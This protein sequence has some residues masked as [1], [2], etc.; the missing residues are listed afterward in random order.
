MR[1][2]Y[3]RSRALAP[4]DSRDP[5]SFSPEQKLLILDVWKRSGLPSAEFGELLGVSHKTLYSWR[6][7]LEKEGPEG[8][9]GKP[10]GPIPGSRIDP[11]TRRAILLIKEDN[12]EYGCDRISQLLY[13]GPG[14]GVSPGG[15]ARVLKE[16]GYQPKDVPT[17]RHP[18]KPR[19]FERAKPNQLW[20]SDL[21]TFTIKRHR[22]RV[23]LTAFMDDHS[24]FITGFGLASSPTSQFIIEVLRSAIGSFGQPEEVLTDQG[25]QYHSWRGRTAFE[26][27]L[28]IRGIRHV[29]SRPRHPQTLGKVERFWKSLWEECLANALFTDI[30]DARKRIGHFIDHYN[31]HRTHQGIDGLYPADRFFGA[32][33]EIRASLEKRVASNALEIAQRGEPSVPFYLTGKVGDTDL[34]VHAEGEKLILT[35]EDGR[36]EEVS[37]ENPHKEPSPAI[38][39][40]LAP[41]GRALDSMEPETVEA[42]PPGA[43]PLDRGLHDL[44][45]AGVD[46]GLVREEDHAQEEE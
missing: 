8:L 37:F 3:K 35:R 23:H 5:K 18:D 28:K 9:F 34:S 41:Q 7:R 46:L 11:I 25:P 42:L 6:T 15:V 4:P 24:R 22:H 43:S 31:F 14:L 26:K 19:R 17:K 27:E 10:K 36:R 45:E 40:P 16:E 30:E 20:Q 33:N 12:P 39:E 2:P 32:E 13:R 21:F 44:E 29:L 1:R 38:P